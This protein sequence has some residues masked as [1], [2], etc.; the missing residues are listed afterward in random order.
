MFVLKKKTE[1][2]DNM[3]SVYKGLMMLGYFGALRG[4]YML[5]QY[6]GDSKLLK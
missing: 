2:G 4:A 5:F 1:Q 6:F 3:S